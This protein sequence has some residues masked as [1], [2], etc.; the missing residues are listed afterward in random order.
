MEFLNFFIDNGYI[1]EFIFAF[2]PLVPLLKGRRYWYFA[3]PPCLL[4]AIAASY[5]TYPDIMNSAT[6]SENLWYVAAFIYMVFAVWLCFRGNLWNAL[7]IC[8]SAY[9]FQHI[10]YIFEKIKEMLLYIAGVD[11]FVLE[12]ILYFLIMCGVYTAMYFFFVA[13]IKKQK[14][15]ETNNVKLLIT[16]IM[17]VLVVITLNAYFQ[18]FFIKINQ[19]YSLPNLLYRVVGLICCFFIINNLYDNVYNKKYKDELKILSLLYEADK[20]QYEVFKQ[21]LETLKIKYHDFKYSVS[22][23]EKVYGDDQWLKE[24]TK[25]LDIYSFMQRTQCDA[26]DVILTEKRLQCDPLGIKINA[27]IDG[28]ILCGMNETDVYALFGNALDNAIES[29]KKITDPDERTIIVEGKRVNSMARITMEN[30]TSEPVTIVDGLP[31]TTK[32]EKEAHGYGAK[33]IK[34]IVEKYNGIVNFSLKEER[35]FILEIILPAKE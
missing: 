25:A 14:D 4:I 20:K 21:N 27:I 22:T 11:S 9:V 5:F 31:K 17:T 15:F 10:F 32:A 26:L 18:M 35:I 30:H 19:F 2:I 12:A 8:T 13:R 16:S 6:L 29:V 33:S 28:R 23:L 7:F 34:R 3:V 24:A 1:Y